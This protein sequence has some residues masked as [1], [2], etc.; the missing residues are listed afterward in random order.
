MIT[1]WLVDQITAQSTLVFSP[2]SRKIEHKF[3]ITVNHYVE[4]KMLDL[5]GRKMTISKPVITFNDEPLNVKSCKTRGS[6]TL[7]FRRKS[8]SVSLKDPLIFQDIAVKKL[9]V[10]NLAL[11]KNY[12]RAR[13]CFLFMNKIGIFPLKN[14]YTE[15]VINGRT[16]GV[17]LMI[18]KPDDYCQL[19]NSKLLLRREDGNKLTVDFARE[20]DARK[21]TKQIKKARTLPK[22]LSGK[23]LSDS[24]SQI[25]NL[26]AYRK[27]L[28]FNYLIMNGDYYDE[29][30]FLLNPET[31]KFDV[32]PWDYDDVFVSEP[33]EGMEKRNKALGDRLLFS[34][35]ADFDRAIAL[36]DYLYH[37]YLNDLNEILLVLSP[38]VLKN[39][40]EQ[41]YQELSPYFINPQVIAQ[42][43]YDHFGLTDID[44]LGEELNWHYQ[45]LIRRREN[46]DLQLTMDN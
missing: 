20:I 9:A 6:S 29:L 22:Y 12:W 43:Q 36:D 33:H 2:S 24:L 45:F 3:D 46:I 34:S 35:E 23:E 17:Y 5:P 14:Q 11:D 1:I 21:K 4:D 7:Q 27:W 18:Q 39:T 32:I 41:V 44:E 30:F 15:L 8:Y 28:A 40:F 19:M 13:L 31:N 26:E 10:N 25:I 38:E 16:Q 37:E 42:S